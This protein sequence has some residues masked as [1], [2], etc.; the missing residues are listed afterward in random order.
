MAHH[1]EPETCSP[2]RTTAGSLLPA[3]RRNGAIASFANVL[4]AGF[5]IFNHQYFDS[6][7]M[8]AI[9]SAATETARAKFDLSMKTATTTATIEMNITVL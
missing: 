9:T 6:K 5:F 8:N 3:T 7:R 1:A 2:T 4:L